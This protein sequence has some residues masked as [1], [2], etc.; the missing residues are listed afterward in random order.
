MRERRELK[1]EI[2]EVGGKKRT[3]RGRRKTAY[4][5]GNGGGAEKTVREASKQAERG[6]GVGEREQ[7]AREE[8]TSS[9]LVSFPKPS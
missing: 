6:E 5:S 7:A 4:R 9:N 2:V 1:G 3:R 8:A